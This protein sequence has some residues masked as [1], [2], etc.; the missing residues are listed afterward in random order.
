VRLRLHVNGVLHPTHGSS[1]EDAFFCAV[2]RRP[3]GMEWM[4]LIDVR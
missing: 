3:D 1:P 2:S 4:T